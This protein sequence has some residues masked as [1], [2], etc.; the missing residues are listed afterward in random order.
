MKE[1]VGI[2]GEGKR[3]KNFFSIVTQRKKPKQRAS[4]RSYPKPHTSAHSP[5]NLSL[6][7]R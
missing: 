7:Q 1:R 3:E 5:S 4:P 2:F 6:E